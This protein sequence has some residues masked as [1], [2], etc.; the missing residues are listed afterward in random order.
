ME[1]ASKIYL[2]DT[3]HFIIG[4]HYECLKMYHKYLIFR[5]SLQDETK[6]NNGDDLYS[7]ARPSTRLPF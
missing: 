7:R 5:I 4:K 6:L 1:E 3:T 2:D